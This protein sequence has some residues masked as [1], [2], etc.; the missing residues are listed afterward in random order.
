MFSVGTNVP[1]PASAIQVIPTAYETAVA[2]AMDMVVVHS[3]GEDG[4][5]GENNEG[6]EE[7][8]DGLL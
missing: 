2:R 7:L 4:E 5:S 6:R 1:L 8:H 3:F